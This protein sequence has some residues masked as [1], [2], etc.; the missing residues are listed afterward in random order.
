[1][2][3]GK[4]SAVLLTK[5][6]FL[7]HRLIQNLGCVNY[8]SRI[9]RFSQIFSHLNVVRWWL[10]SSDNSNLKIPRKSAYSR[11]GKLKFKNTDRVAMF[12]MVASGNSNI[13][14]G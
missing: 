1:M 6:Y 10:Y 12:K 8:E 4:N 2:Y 3:R 5:H 11:W 14:L 7:H 9:L 13:E